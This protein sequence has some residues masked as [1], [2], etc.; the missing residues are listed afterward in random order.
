MPNTALQ[1]QLILGKKKSHD[2]MFSKSLQA[3]DAAV[4]SRSCCYTRAH[5]H[6]GYTHTLTMQAIIS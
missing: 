5:T 4:V 2:K 3:D 1:S 6:T